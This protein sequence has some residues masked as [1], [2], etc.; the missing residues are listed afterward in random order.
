MERELV[1]GFEFAEFM[2]RGHLHLVHLQAI[3][4]EEQEEAG[5]DLTHRSICLLFVVL[6]I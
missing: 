3:G 4:K 5:L 2:V 1:G 6:E